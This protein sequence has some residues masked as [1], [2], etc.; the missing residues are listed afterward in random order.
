MS[1]NEESINDPSRDP[2]E[3]N[4]RL[5]TNEDLPTRAER[6]NE[7]QC[8]I[9][10]LLLTVKD[11]EFL[12]CISYLSPDYRKCRD[13]EL[14]DF[15]VGDMG[16]DE[17]VKTKVAVIQ[18]YMGSNNPGSSTTVVTKAVNILRPRAV[19]CVG[20]CGGLNSK[21][22]KVGDV[23]ILEKLVTYSS[24]KV[25]GNGIIE[26]GVRV[27]MNTHCR[28]LVLSATHGWTPPLK[29]RTA[30]D[31]KAKRGVFLSGPQVVASKARREELIKRF[32]DA[33]AIEMEGEGKCL[34]NL[35]PFINQLKAFSMAEKQKS[36]SVYKMSV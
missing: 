26:R 13:V 21:K 19:F 2:P 14:G 8:P 7:V 16:K 35:M 5:L 32:P 15:F 36:L 1:G 30:L 3:L 31:V 4:V 9:D 28:K 11:C 18:C 24:C 33:V 25:T 10:I 20:F 23:V 17:T 22:V 27:P 34:Q 6:W 29:D 12:S